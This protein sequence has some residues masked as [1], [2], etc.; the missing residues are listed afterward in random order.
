MENHQLI[1]FEYQNLEYLQE[2][3]IQENETLWEEYLLK[4]FKQCCKEY[5]VNYSLD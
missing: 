3:F 2:H 4:T 5:P 1:E